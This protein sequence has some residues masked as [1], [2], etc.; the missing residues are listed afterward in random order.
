MAKE[1]GGGSGFSS[2]EAMKRAV[3]A[4]TDFSST[5]VPALA[6]FFFVRSCIVEPFYIPSMSMYPTLRVNDQVAVEKFSRFL[7][8][9]RRGDL[10]VFTPP[11]AYLQVRNAAFP[12]QTPQTRA[13]ALVKRVVA[14]ENDR[15]EVRNGIFTLNGTPMYEP[16]V[17]ELA[18][19]T[20]PP[21]IVPQGKLFVLGD[22][23]NDS[24]DS[25]VWGF[26]P[27]ANV[28]GKAFYI[29]WP[30]GRQGFVDA[31][32]QDLQVTQDVDEFISRLPGLQRG[33]DGR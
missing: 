9:P 31:F 6:L 7:A 13:N 8:P 20:L 19:Y 10:V 11:E 26:L 28:V 24:S 32:M 5:F 2:R 16:Y 33:R 3:D 4:V 29:V 25:H 30:I 21:L 23:R 22:N 12:E 17:S 14:I 18:R 27:T 15:V 1:R